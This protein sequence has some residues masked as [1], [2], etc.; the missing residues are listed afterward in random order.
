MQKC[1]TLSSTESEYVA[2]SQCAQ[3][4]IFVKQFLDSLE[5]S[6][7]LPMTIYVDNTGSMDL[8]KSWMSSGNSKHI[9]IRHHFIRNLV[10][11]GVI[12]LEFV[13]SDDNLADSFTKNIDQSRYL[14]HKDIMMNLRDW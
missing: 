11:D 13:P 9:D 5:M 12:H 4:L 2:L 7:E 6:V 3:D 8:A 10:E 1:V 14:V